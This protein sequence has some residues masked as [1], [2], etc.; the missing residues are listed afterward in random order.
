[1]SE[2]NANTVSPNERLQQLLK[3]TESMS[4]LLE[5]FDINEPKW[6]E[7]LD[8]ENK[9]EKVLQEFN[10]H[11]FPVEDRR[12]ALN[13]LQKLVELDKSVMET[14]TEY[15]QEIFELIKQ[16]RAAKQLKDNIKDYEE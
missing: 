13:D 1:M 10:I 12:S 7:F 5:N 9:R 15:K 3:I 2:D 14:V 6:D 8:L 4:A 16:I 11:D